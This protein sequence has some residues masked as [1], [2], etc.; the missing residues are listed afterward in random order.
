MNK[1]AWTAFIIAQIAGEICFW[2]WEH[3]SPPVGMLLWGAALV[4]LFPGNFLSAAII[5]P[6]FWGKLS[7]IQLAVLEVPLEI[8]INFVV[9]FISMAVLKVVWQKILAG[10]KRNNRSSIYKW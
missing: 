1:K 9:W 4:L 2:S 10:L 3:I 7:L 8:P 5:E 6:V